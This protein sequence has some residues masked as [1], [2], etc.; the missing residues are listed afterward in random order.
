[1]E[2]LRHGLRLMAIAA[3]ATAL[4]AYLIGDVINEAYVDKNLPGIVMLALV[5]AFVFLVKALATYGHT[6]ML[7]R[8]GNRIIAVNQR[9][10]FNALIKQNVAFFSRTALLGIHGA[11]DHRRHRRKPR[12]QPAGHR[13][14]PRSAL[15]DRPARGDGGARP[16][17]V[18]LQ[19][20]RGAAGASSCCAR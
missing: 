13:D 18:V 5:T 2:A 15:A 9:R 4:S 11:A 1:M 10:M 7:S 17:H 12:D 20:R 14:R 3:G 6:V 16:D 8:I 19:P